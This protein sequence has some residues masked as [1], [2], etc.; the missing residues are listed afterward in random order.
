MNRVYLGDID[1]NNSIISPLEIRRR[2]MFMLLIWD[3]IVLS[4][5]QFLT[6]P[7]VNLL[8]SG[9][10]SKM[11]ADE[12]NLQDL[13]PKMKGFEHL[14]ENALV[15]IACRSTNDHVGSL[16]ELWYEMSHRDSQ[17]PFLPRPGY[18]EYLDSL[19]C[20]QEPYDLTEIGD[21]FRNNLLA[22]LGK[23]VF[24]N[25]TPQERKIS[26]LF[27]EDKVNFSKIYDLLKQFQCDGSITSKKYN[28]IYDY[29]YSCYSINI[30]KVT[31]C[32]INTNFK[33]IP[34]H[35]GCGVG[36]YEDNIPWELLDPLRPTWVLN[37]LILDHI[38]LE[39]FVQIRKQVQIYI[40][41]SVFI[42]YFNGTLKESQLDQF[43]NL[44]EMYTIHLESLMRET[45]L[46][47]QVGIFEQLLT[48]EGIKLEQRT[49]L[50]GSWELVKNTIAPGAGLFNPI[51]A[52]IIGAGQL[53][54]ATSKTVVSLSHQAQ[55]NELVKRERDIKLLIPPGSKVITKY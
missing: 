30:S 14:L 3:K 42:D 16:S 34:I 9:Y 1:P 40:S 2:F 47:E 36:D 50:S 35:L 8:M 33:N 12:L 48:I 44:W 20:E 18:A 43:F 19:S 10:D 37:P 39:D 52:G 45:L 5:S 15:D 38:S 23:D 29:I 31:G 26:E 41:Q 11:L 28:Q 6:D 7:R 49:I 54:E 22:G 32:Y 21:C 4:D 13:K 27:Q 25:V 46:R 17:V 53:I 24:P 55:W 51:V